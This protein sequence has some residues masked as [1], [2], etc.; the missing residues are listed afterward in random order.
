[1]IYGWASYWYVK[2]TSDIVFGEEIVFSDYVLIK[3]QI[4][5]ALPL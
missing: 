1:M 2:N 3:Y 5:L 4:S